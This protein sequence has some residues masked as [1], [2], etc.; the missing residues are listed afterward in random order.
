MQLQR[1]LLFTFVVFTSLLTCHYVEA[2]GGGRGGG[3]GG[4]R[5]GGSRGA[6]Q[7]INRTPTMSRAVTPS[8]PMQ[9][10]QPRTQA[11][12][13]QSHPQARQAHSQIQQT[14]PLRSQIQP[15]IQS[16]RPQLSQPQARQA[17]SQVQQVQSQAKQFVRQPANKE[18]LRS[19]INQYASQ[20]TPSIDKQSFSQRQQAF[21][22]QRQDKVLQNQQVSQNVSQRLQRTRQGYNNWFGSDFF[23]DHN[24][25]VDE[26]HDVNWWRAAQWTSLARWGDWD[27]STPYYYDYGD[28]P[29]PLDAS[30][31]NQGYSNP[32]VPIETYPEPVT[33][34]GEWVPLGVFTIASSIDEAGVSNRIIQLAINRTGE[35][36]GVFYNT[37]TNTTHTITGKVVP[38]TQRAYW[39]LT[40]RADSPILSTGIY[41]LTE[42]QTPVQVYFPN[43][44]G[45]IWTLVRL[46]NAG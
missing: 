3:G 20:P 9:A 25:Y 17:R 16:A 15:Q 19:Q 10:V 31:Y 42:E 32:A 27:W 35:L 45:Q 36:S 30:A 1:T 13:P 43:G 39:S 18:Q 21:H 46:Y 22:D 44:S 8:R 24:L 2:R 12:R 4:G 26:R 23:R 34:G 11:V 38:E 28:Y 7:A 6:G 14:Q 33:Y 29:I 5:G 41:N 37:A 40:D